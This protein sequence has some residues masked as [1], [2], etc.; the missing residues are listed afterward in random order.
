MQQPE[1]FRVGD[2]VR[3]NSEAGYVSGLV[4]KVH[5]ADFDYKGH[6]H[7]ASPDRPQYEIRSDRTDHIA[8][9][10]GDVLSKVEDG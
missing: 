10:Y 1:R 6:R 2:H 3:W 9:H 4:V 5:T 7:R 8:A